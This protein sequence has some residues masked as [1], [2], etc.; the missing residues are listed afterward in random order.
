MRSEA[1][2]LRG[3]G[4]GDLG[5]FRTPRAPK[6]EAFKEDPPY[7]APDSSRSVRVGCIEGVLNTARMRVQKTIPFVSNHNKQNIQHIRLE[8]ATHPIRDHFEVHPKPSYV[9]V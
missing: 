8:A 9:D 1:L 3:E 7:E 5:T 6:P 4:P 2:S